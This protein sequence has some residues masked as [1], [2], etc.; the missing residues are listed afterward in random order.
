MVNSLVGPASMVVGLGEMALVMVLSDLGNGVVRISRIR[1]VDKPAEDPPDW[2]ALQLPL[3][4][5]VRDAICEA[6]AYLGLLSC[7]GILGGVCRQ[8]GDDD[9]E[10][11]VYRVD[12]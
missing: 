8:V 6:L 3:S 7:G 10:Y 12:S 5:R 4:L 1:L 11:M 2:E 9:A